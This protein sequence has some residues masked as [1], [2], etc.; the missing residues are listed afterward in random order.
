MTAASESRAAAA[1]TR[2]LVLSEQLGCRADR[3]SIGEL[4]EGLGRAALGLGLMV[5]SL[6]ALIPLPGPFGILF[7]AMIG[8]IAVQVMT[9][10]TRL[11]L[12][13]F[14]A[15]RTV[16]SA[17][18]GTAV[19]H[20]AAPLR[21]AERLSTPRRL[22]PLTG[23][24]AR[25]VL[26][27]PLLLMAMTLAL[28]IPLGNGLPAIAVIVFALGFMERDGLAILAAL[29]LCVVALVWTTILILFGVEIA[30]W[31]LGIFR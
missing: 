7:G 11:R 9:G 13:R 21:W 3:V 22:L 19:R 8:A 31:V 10:E 2:L 18:V 29:G 14:L 15:V 25:V 30:D 16:P 5:P 20:F 27:A 23:R 17:A 4:L 28:P 1:S 24:V 6:L 12:P 26:A